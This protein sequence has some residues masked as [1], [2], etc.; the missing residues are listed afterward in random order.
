MKSH[1]NW[2]LLKFYNRFFFQT[3][4]IILSVR[5]SHCL[6]RPTESETAAI[7]FLIVEMVLVPF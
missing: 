1:R 4:H 5:S 6:A 2:E 7:S 3:K